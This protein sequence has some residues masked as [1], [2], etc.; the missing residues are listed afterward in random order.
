M[1]FRIGEIYIFSEYEHPD[2]KEKKNRHVVILV[3]RE[4]TDGFKLL[5][6]NACQACGVACEVYT[7]PLFEHASK[8]N[9]LM[10]K[11]KYPFLD[12]D[13]YCTFLRAASQRTCDKKLVDFKGELHK[14]DI[15]EFVEKLK[16]AYSSKRMPKELS[17]NFFMGV[18][19]REWETLISN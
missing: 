2:V 14:D 5:V 16:Q 3:S 7:S 1:K 11:S 4:L 19:I 18:L 15:I 12:D 13:R 17:S 6:R 8:D 9:F 10:L